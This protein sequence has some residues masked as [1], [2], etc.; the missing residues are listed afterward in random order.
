MT[1]PTPRRRQSALITAVRFAGP[2]L[3]P[4]VML[5]MHT[6]AR[7]FGA[8]S[9][10]DQWD[11]DHLTVES[12]EHALG[13]IQEYWMGIAGPIEVILLVLIIA[14]PTRA[15]IPLLAFVCGAVFDELLADIA[16]QID[17]NYRFGPRSYTLV[18]YPLFRF[19]KLV[20]PA[21]VALW[22][23]AI[24][25]PWRWPAI[26]RDGLTHHGAPPV[27]RTLL[28][29]TLIALT[30]SVV[31]TN[32][33]QLEVFLRALTDN[34]LWE[35]ESYTSRERIRDASVV[36]LAVLVAS[37][38]LVMYS[39]RCRSALPLYALLLA[40]VTRLV[41]LL[42]MGIVWLI[43]DAIVESYEPAVVAILCVFHAI[44]TRAV[45]AEAGIVC[46]EC[47]YI[48]GPGTRG[49]CSECGILTNERGRAVSVESERHD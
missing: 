37:A 22:Y 3:L 26:D 16:L 27:W 24:A 35:R 30:I 21:T 40:S 39:Q 25:K 33:A 49:R 14:F 42:G 36:I 29:W 38:A 8:E 18:Q 2:L 31:A 9:L 10:V 13:T 20:L 12:W 6:W 19:G 34:R 4:H 46:S 44:Q 41:C 11:T 28:V 15:A 45:A 5:R 48:V 17:E 7:M 23:F 1:L 43:R 47:G 32:Y